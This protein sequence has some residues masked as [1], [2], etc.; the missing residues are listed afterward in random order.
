HLRIWTVLL[1]A[2]SITAKITDY[3]TSNYIP[4][5]DGDVTI[6]KEFQ[7]LKHSTNLTM[8]SEI[9]KDTEEMEEHF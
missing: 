6:W 8:Y 7:Y 2:V 9:V 4:I 1:L 5:V 3:T